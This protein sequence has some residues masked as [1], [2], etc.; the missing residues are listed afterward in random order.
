MKPQY[1]IIDLMG[2]ISLQGQ[3]SDKIAIHNIK[4]IIENKNSNKEM[5]KRYNWLKKNHPELII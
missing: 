1:R 5:K 3:Y 2:L 4:T